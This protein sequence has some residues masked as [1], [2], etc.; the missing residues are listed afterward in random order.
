M[1]EGRSQY[2][3]AYF[4]RIDPGEAE[5]LV[6]LLSLPSDWRLCSSDGIVFKVLANVQKGEQGISLEE[7]LNRIGMSRPLRKQYTKEFRTSL[8]QLGAI[9]SIQDRGRKR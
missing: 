6:R 2:D 4:E 7:V 9:D 1:A 3:A 8:T 5:A